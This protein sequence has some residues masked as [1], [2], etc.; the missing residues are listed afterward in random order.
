MQLQLAHIGINTLLHTHTRL[1]VTIAG[2][3]EN[4]AHDQYQKAKG[5]ECFI[6]FYFGDVYR[7]NIH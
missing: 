3:N 4:L 7:I 6:P 5:I 1:H 2:V